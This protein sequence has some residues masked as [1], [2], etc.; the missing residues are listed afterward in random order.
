MSI[1]IKN[2]GTLETVTGGRFKDMDV[3]IEG[4]SVK[5]VGKCLKAK[6]ERM[7]DAKGLV[8][9]PGFVN[10]HHH[11]YQTFTRNLP[12]A[13]NAELFPWLK[14][15]YR[16][17]QHLEEE[18][19][20]VS[21]LTALAELMLTGVTTT[22]DHL[23]LY[24]ASAKE[25]WMEN[26]IKAA[27]D[28][29]MR[30]Y[31]TRGSMSLSEKDG[32][33]PP[34][35]VVQTEESIMAHIDGIIS[36]YHDPSEYSML[37]I[38]L[39]PCS[40]FSV[41]PRLMRET[42]DYA[43]K[44]GLLIHTHLAET[45]DEETFCIEKFGKRPYEYI[46]DLGW[47]GSNAWFAHSIY[48]NE[49]EID[50]LAAT[51]SGVSHCPSSN[52]RLGSGIAA[53]PSMLKKGVK[54]SLGVDGSSSNDSSDF[55][56]EIRQAL[57]LGRVGFGASALTTKDVLE[58]GT[59]GG[60]AVLNW[61]DSIGSIEPGKAADITLWDLNDISYIGAQSDPV[62]ALIFSG[63]RHAAKYVIVNGKVTVE[64]YKL[65]GIDEAELIERGM[66]LSSALWKR[67][68]LK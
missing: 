34:D 48:L 57:L 41:T 27:S 5:T 67:A 68:G 16:I 56:A 43:K 21:S 11:F 44:K 23:Y 51:G 45:R 6:P 28:I 22:T 10:T 38:A 52:M 58:M 49:K 13:Q 59:K 29:G 62:A 54:V 30:F 60:A 42:A 19:I 4:H 63:R 25:H 15:H 2:I 3:L 36:K 55:L 8:A 40:P 9:L 14:F 33:L 53:I 18:D 66:R 47:A 17:W 65:T 61:S 7:I 24:N 31:P 20:Y 64:D 26:E 12:D 37:R 1:L 46:K 35:D 39:A 50:D 32:G